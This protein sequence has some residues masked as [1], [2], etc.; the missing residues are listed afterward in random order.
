MAPSASSPTRRRFQRCTSPCKSTGLF[1]ALR[2]SRKRPCAL[3]AMAASSAD[4]SVSPSSDRSCCPQRLTGMRRSVVAATRQSGRALKA[5]H[6]PGNGAQS[7]RRRR[8]HHSKLGRR[9]RT[10][11]RR[12]KS[13]QSLLL[14]LLFAHQPIRPE[15]QS[16]TALRERAFR[17]ILETSGA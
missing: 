11:C 12:R 16:Y 3:G 1:G 4:G 6:R 14:R 17:W 13:R 5:A 8:F 2:R 7:V 9:S 15:R 10:L